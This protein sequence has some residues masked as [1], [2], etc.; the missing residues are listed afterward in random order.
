MYRENERHHFLSVD[1]K[2]L[3]TGIPDIQEEDL[4]VKDFTRKIITRKIRF[5]DESGEKMLVGS[6]HDI[7]ERKYAEDALRESEDK[8][9][10]VFDHS[11][12]GKSITLPTGEIHVNRA[13]CDIT[14][15]SSAELE[16]KKWQEISHP[17]DT[18]M[19]EK[20]IAS[21]SSGEKKSARF[22]KRYI[23]KNGNVIWTDVGTTLRRNT[24][25]EPIYFM[26]AII[27]ITERKIAEAEIKELNQVL[28]LR[29][30]QRT[31]Q[32]E[33]ANKELESFSYSVSHDLRSPLRA[34]HS[35]T[36]ILLEDY[37]SKL[38][39]EGK[40]LFRIVYSSAAQMGDL[41]D[42]L[43]NLSRIGRSSMT[44]SLV[45]MNNMVTSVI[46]EMLSEK[47]KEE[48]T[49]NI[50]RLD[51][52]YCDQNLIIQV[53]INLISNAIKYS[54]K[55][56]NPVINIGS[57]ISNNMINY[58]VSDNGVGFDMTYKHKLFGVFQRLHTEREF[59][60]NGVGL[61]IVQRI[62]NRHAGKVW[63]EGEVG[64]GAIFCFSLP[65]VSEA[66]R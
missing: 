43:L 45:D 49:I 21:L 64:K 8:F 9:K 28:E 16:R 23:H 6:I 41:I 3:D 62:I 56:D 46:N 44:L 20:I 47:E 2:V 5:I 58:Y 29:V 12:I 18:E 11:V 14:G 33:E 54:S 30:K 17:D 42:D 36:K 15:Y 24:D 7:T 37:E 27:D 40:R 38:D 50:E 48:K 59:E 10:Y 65:D 57:Q 26:T 22:I 25:G 35:Y 60:G 1:R 39:D 32:L 4:T 19:T 61:A 52:A 53:W 34:V 66:I 51:K 31:E 13:F 55:E 63:A